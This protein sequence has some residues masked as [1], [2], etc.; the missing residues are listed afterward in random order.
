MNQMPTNPSNH[1]MPLSKAC[2]DTFLGSTGTTSKYQTRLKRRVIILEEVFN[3]PKPRYAATLS[4]SEEKKAPALTALINWLYYKKKRVLEPRWIRT[5]R[6]PSQ[7]SVLFGYSSLRSSHLVFYI[8]GG[9]ILK[10]LLLIAAILFQC[11]ILCEACL[12][13]IIYVIS[14][15]EFYLYIRFLGRYF[16]KTF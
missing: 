4:E 3:L 10:N 16:I 2:L 12:R 11:Y 15:D 6:T 5:F 14:W 7:H 9:T 13:F 1:V 8:T